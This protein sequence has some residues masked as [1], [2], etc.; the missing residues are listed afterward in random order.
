[1]GEVAQFRERPKRSA[2]VRSAVPAVTFFLEY[3]FIINICGMVAPDNSVSYQGFL[4]PASQMLSLLA[5]V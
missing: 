4:N 1:V 3:A 5:N 2:L